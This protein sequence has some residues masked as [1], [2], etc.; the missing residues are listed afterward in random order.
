MS[1]RRSLGGAKARAEE[2]RKKRKKTL[3][4]RIVSAGMTETGVTEPGLRLRSH[5]PLPL[6]EQ[7]LLLRSSKQRAGEVGAGG[8]A[9]KA[10]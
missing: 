5:E 10:T 7:F 4:K 3:A 2:E 1:S 8:E 9:G 6:V